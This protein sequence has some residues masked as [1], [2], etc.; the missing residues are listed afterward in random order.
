MDCGGEEEVGP[1]LGECATVGKASKAQDAGKTG[2]GFPYQYPAAGRQLLCSHRPAVSWP[3]PPSALFLKHCEVLTLS[4]ST[5]PSA[6]YCLGSW[7]LFYS[8]RACSSKPQFLHLPKGDGSIAQTI[9]KGPSSCSSLS[10]WP[11]VPMPSPAWCQGRL[12]A[13]R[14]QPVSPLQS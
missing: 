9:F 12:A 3:C 7:H 6:F 11:W 8:L 2:L 1:C 13:L 10:L 5:N 14:V 4:P